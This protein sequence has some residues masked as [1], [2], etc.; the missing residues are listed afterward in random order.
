MNHCKTCKFW[1]WR[2]FP[3]NGVADCDKVNHIDTEKGDKAFFVEA[4]AHDDSGL[5]TTLMTGE[6]FG[7][8]HHQPKE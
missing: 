1:S 8:I 4:T 5:D 7:C 3:Q 2:L 6:N